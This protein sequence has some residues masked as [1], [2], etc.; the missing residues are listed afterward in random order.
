VEIR[1]D[2]YTYGVTKPRRDEWNGRV[3]SP[4]KQALDLSFFQKLLYL[5]LENI[6]LYKICLPPFDIDTAIKLIR[7]SSTKAGSMSLWAAF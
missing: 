7:N 2:S 3:V 4:V 6:Y 1:K 5:C